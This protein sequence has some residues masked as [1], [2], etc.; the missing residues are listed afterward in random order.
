MVRAHL[1]ENERHGRCGKQPYVREEEH[2]HGVRRFRLACSGWHATGKWT[3]DVTASEVTAF[4][5]V[6]VD[7]VLAAQEDRPSL[8]DAT[9]AG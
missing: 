3:K 7:A 8:G 5:R 9:E 1:E 4:V 6:F 2:T